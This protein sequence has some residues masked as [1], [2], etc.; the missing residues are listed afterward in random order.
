M[1][2]VDVTKR[3]VFVFTNGEGVETL[4]QLTL[5]I[6]LQRAGNTRSSH[7][8][9]FEAIP[10][11]H[12]RHRYDAVLSNNIIPDFGNLFASRCSSKYELK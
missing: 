2:E 10:E 12:V 4:G 1:E 5:F 8:V 6:W 9:I 11:T 7:E 3:Q